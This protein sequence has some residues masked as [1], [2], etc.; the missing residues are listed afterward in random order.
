MVKCNPDFEATFMILGYLNAAVTPLVYYTHLRQALG[1]KIRRL[2][3][4]RPAQLTAAVLSKSVCSVIGRLDAST[5]DATSGIK[6][7]RG[8][9]IIAGLENDRLTIGHIS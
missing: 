3:S 4:R 6:K 2:T 9:S 5:I 7:L 8:H 1:R